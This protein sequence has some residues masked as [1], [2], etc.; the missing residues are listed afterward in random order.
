MSVKRGTFGVNQ[1]VALQD[2]NGM[3]KAR[4]LEP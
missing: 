3:V 2:P 1:N 4:L